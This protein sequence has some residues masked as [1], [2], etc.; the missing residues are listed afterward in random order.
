MKIARAKMGCDIWLNAYGPDL[1]GLQVCMEIMPDQKWKVRTAG[2][3][4]FLMR[5]GAPTLRLTPA[6]FSRLFILEDEGK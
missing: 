2:G 4:I 5:K 3:Y 6:A 1:N